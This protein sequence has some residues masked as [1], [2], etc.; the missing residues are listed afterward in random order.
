MTID[1][2]VAKATA[3]LQRAGVDKSA[4]DI[5][6]IIAK[7]C[8]FKPDTAYV[9]V[10][11]APDN[12]RLVVGDAWALKCRDI[13]SCVH[14]HFETEFYLSMDRH[15]R[16]IHRADM[17]KSIKTHTT[18]IKNEFSMIEATNALYEA[19][20]PEDRLPGSPTLS[21]EVKERRDTTGIY[22]VLVQQHSAVTK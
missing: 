2:W 4:S 9:E 19:L 21:V 1:P 20:P 6:R 15:L 8:P 5:A 11:L 17:P 16:D 7:H 18:T 3:E 10:D 12:N 13:W 14:C 22:L